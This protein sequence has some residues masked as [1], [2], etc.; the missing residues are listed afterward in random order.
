M[1]LSTTRSVFG[2]VEAL[3]A[4]A[5]HLTV[6]AAQK[7]VA[8]RG[9]FTLALTGGST[10]TALYPL[11]AFAPL[12]WA[13]MHVFFGDERCLPGDHVDS[14]HRLA[15]ETLLAARRL[16]AAHLHRIVG[17]D[18]PAAAARQAEHALLQATDGTGV[19]D[20]VHLGVGPD[21]HVCSLFPGHPVLGDEVRLFAGLS[22]SPKPPPS[23]VT[24]TLQALS[25]A[26]HL[27]FFALGASKAD[28]VAEAIFAPDGTLPAA[29]VAR[30]GQHVRWLLD[31]DAARFVR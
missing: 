16:P 20:L 22:D 31:V 18:G 17:E 21:G 10:A 3:G 2:S 8:A 28:A 5:L 7:A 23:R 11:L 15:Q 26:R 9:R 27:W 1:A 13:H 14:N 12:P 24:L 19:L 6:A 29:V 30:R 25:R 4:E